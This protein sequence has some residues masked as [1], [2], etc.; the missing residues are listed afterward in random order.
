[1]L[2]QRADF[3]IIRDSQPWGCVVMSVFITQ[4]EERS[5]DMLADLLIIRWDVTIHLLV[6]W[7]HIRPL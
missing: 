4:G 7:G 5:Q 1:M 6:D 2:T 3:L